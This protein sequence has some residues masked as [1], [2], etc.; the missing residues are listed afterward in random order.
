MGTVLEIAND[1]KYGCDLGT[2]GKHLCPSTSTNAPSAWE[3]GA[4]VTDSIV[5]G[6]IN[7]I[8][9]G[10]MKEEDIPF[11][12]VKVNGLMVKL[13]DNGVA[14]NCMNMSRGEPF[15]AND[16]MS[17]NDRFEVSMS[18]T[19]D[20]LISLNSAGRGSWFCKLDWSGAYKQL[21]T[22]QSDVRQQFFK[23]GGQQMVC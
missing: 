12:S 2:R 3:F 23:W 18:T 5:D 16:G 17:N 9:I 20:W 13:K 8:I 7:G 11:E 19:R 6:I 1:V 21:R 15:C 10:P 4:R 22:K 14:R